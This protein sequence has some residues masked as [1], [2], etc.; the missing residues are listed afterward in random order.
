MNNDEGE[1]SSVASTLFNQTRTYYSLRIAIDE[2]FVPQ[3]IK[4]LGKVANVMA[5]LIVMLAIIYYV[6]Q[7]T[8]FTSIQEYITVI[9]NSEKRIGDIVNINLKINDLKMINENILLVANYEQP[10]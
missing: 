3:A 2:K 5:C 7:Y 6:I 9:I 1:L 10:K 4:N 8:L